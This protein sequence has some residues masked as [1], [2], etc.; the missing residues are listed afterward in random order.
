M[1]YLSNLLRK[2][3]CILVIPCMPSVHGI[4]REHIYERH[5]ELDLFYLILL[6]VRAS[7]TERNYFYMKDIILLSN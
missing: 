4:L 5:I 1:I 3:L 2:Q 7:I 6:E